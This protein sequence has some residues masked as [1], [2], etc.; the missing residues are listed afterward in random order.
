MKFG[1]KPIYDY[2]KLD[3]QITEMINRGMSRAATARALGCCDHTVNSRVLN[4]GLTVADQKG[5]GRGTR[6]SGY[7]P[8]IEHLAALSELLKLVRSVKVKTNLPTGQI[9][10]EALELINKGEMSLKKAVN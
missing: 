5:I 1:R 6:A 8:P 4:L 2:S 10:I 3:P 7:N 9:I